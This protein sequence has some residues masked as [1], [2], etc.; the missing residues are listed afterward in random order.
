MEFGRSEYGPPTNFDS[1]FVDKFRLGV[2]RTNGPAHRWCRIV[3][4]RVYIETTIPSYLAA[5][6][7]RDLLQAA[8]QQI[9]HDW[10]NNER[11]NY[12]LCIS[13]IVLDEAFSGD[14]DAA[15]RRLTFLVDLPLLDVTDAVNVVAK[16][17]MD[18]GLLPQKATRDAIHI[19]VASVHGIDFLL[20]WNCRHIANA[21]IMK[22]LQ[23]IL[24]NFDCEIPTIC[25]PEE[26][27]GE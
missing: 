5:W 22:E 9:T 13:E 11:A 26:L 2:S 20:T 10:W 16:A 15:K 25:T 7:S 23:T 24:A 12:E 19:A 18:S 14:S 21:A 27:F 3:T 1:F 4:K 8:R 6:P 17:I